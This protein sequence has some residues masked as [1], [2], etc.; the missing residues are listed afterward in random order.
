[1][2]NPRIAFLQSNGIN[3]SLAL[4][5][6]SATLRE[7]GRETRLFLT[8][9]DR[10]FCEAV[11]RYDP[12]IV[13]LPCDIMGHNW[14]LRTARRLKAE[15]SAPVVFGGVLPTFYPEIIR[16]SSVDLVFR[17]EAEGVVL[18]L[19]EKLLN[20][21]PIENIPNLVVLQDGGVKANPMRPL[22]QDLD[23][24]PLPD[25]ALYYRFPFIR[26]FGWKKFSSSRGCVNNC[27]YCFNPTFKSMLEPGGRFLRR[28]SAER[29]L[30]EILSVK[31]TY[32]L[33]IVHFSDDI[34]TSG[35]EW[36]ESFAE[37]FPSRIG[38]PF[39]CNVYA[40]F[41]TPEAVR[42]LKAAGCVTLSMGVETA[43]QNRRMDLLNKRLTD[44]E[45]LQAAEEIKKAGIFLITFNMLGLPGGSIEED[46]KTLDLNKKIGSGHQRVA[47]TVP[48]PYSKMAEECIAD[49]LL[50]GDFRNRV[51]EL[52]DLSEASRDTMYRI[53]D[54]QKVMSL[55]ALWYLFMRLPFPVSRL[56]FLLGLPL[57]PLYRL[58][59]FLALP[60]EKRAFRLRWSEGI[61]YFLHVGSTANKTT[62]YVTLI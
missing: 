47:V 11:R 17:G 53:P 8:G 61:R 54:R 33:R 3:E 27:G 60:R 5:E 13:I 58:F 62:N 35:T 34:F 57:L 20:K 51:L 18:E 59:M 40:K 23:A 41:V 37:A 1:M 36:L 45:I 50:P 21:K 48:I 43:D 49:G 22:I 32:P 4:T 9:E 25:R 2:T 42:L 19:S 39:S 16:E 30:E 15:V 12:Q 52:P 28:K 46:L 26:D 31:K 44:E 56:R 14:A 38:L 10:R 29:I 7:N 6:L 24:L 55:Y